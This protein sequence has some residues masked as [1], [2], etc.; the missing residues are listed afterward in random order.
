[1]IVKSRTTLGLATFIL[2]TSALN[3]LENKTVQKHI[4][5]IG[6]FMKIGYVSS[7]AIGNKNGDLFF[8]GSISGV[9]QVYRLTDEGWPYQLTVFDDGINWYK[10]SYAGDKAIVGASRGGTEDTQLYLMDTQSGRI[11]QIT[12]NPKVRH[13]SVVW[14]KDGTGFFYRAN[15][16][17][18]RDFKLYFHGLATGENEKVFDMEGTNGVADLSYDERYLI[19]YHAYSS[20]SNELYMIDLLDNSFEMITPG[21][22]GILYDYPSL[23][24]DNKTLY[25]ICNDNENGI[26]ALARLNIG[27]KKL[28]FLEP[29]LKWTVD[30]LAVSPNRNYAAWMINEEGYSR[31]KLHHME[32]N[33]SLP[34]PSVSG[35]VPEAVLSDDGLLFFRF[36]SPT[37][38]SDIWIWDWKRPELK[39]VTHST[40]AG[41]DPD[42][43]MEP[44]LVKYKSFDG[45]EIPAFLFL[46]PDYRGEPV[47][48]IIH[49]HGGPEEQFRPYFQRHF[50]YLLLNGY[51][52]LAP[53]VRGS[54]GYGKEYINLDNYK[55]RLNSIKDYKA[56]VD[57]LIKNNFTRKGMIGIK[58]ASYG[59]YVAL[60]GITEYP[61]LFSAAV[62]EFGIA[63][64]VTFLK[65]TGDYRRHIR[66]SEY[67]PLTDEPF[68]ESISPIHKA[69]RIRTPLLVIHGENDPRVPVGEAR[70]IIKAVQEYGGTVDSLIFPDERHH[71]SKL[72]NR[73]VLY[74]RMVDFFDR[75]LKK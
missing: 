27:N 69:S 11:V 40:Y 58:G 3:A 74:R 67:G 29:E 44:T 49:A 21:K 59:G 7:P 36:T 53:N 56:G 65:N 43:F 10:L 52:I 18:P 1:M 2:M 48:F 26:G 19:V 17:N 20:I 38:T 72:S 8:I 15:S 24:P 55:N 60:A 25:F 28:E 57:Y 12:D 70:Q 64:F 37:R 42:I 33:V 63:N 41:I 71:A 9:D 61:D 47:P 30:N 54:S 66:E 6:T 46:P 23:M 14:K 34:E 35:F 4:H 68:L 62:D 5:D 50:Q 31:I 51:G 45:L 13:G 39:K 32:K 73:L 16:E 22:K 75:Y